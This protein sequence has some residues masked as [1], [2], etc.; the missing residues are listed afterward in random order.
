[1]F[2]FIKRKAWKLGRAKKPYPPPQALNSD[3]ISAPC[4][5]QFFSLYRH[6]LRL[7][8]KN[9]QV[10]LCAHS[11]IPSLITAKTSTDPRL[12]MFYSIYVQFSEEHSWQPMKK[13]QQSSKSF[14]QFLFVILKCVKHVSSPVLLS[15]EPKQAACM[16]SQQ[17]IPW[18]SKW[19]SPLLCTHGQFWKC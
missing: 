2:C 5:S 3:I 18:Q 9:K 11:T 10:W 19:G 7:I 12:V 17:N 14:W 16:P 15:S 8:F 13:P 6:S 4:P 1:M